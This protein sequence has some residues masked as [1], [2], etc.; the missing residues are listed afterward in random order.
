MESG[1]VVVVFIIVATFHNLF[2]VIIQE[3]NFVIY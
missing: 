1:V 3:C 2:L